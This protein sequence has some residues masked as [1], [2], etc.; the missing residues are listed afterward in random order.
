MAGREQ[1]NTC[2]NC[3]TPLTPLSHVLAP[4]P[5]QAMAEELLDSS[6]VPALTGIA[7]H[8]RQPRLV[9][10]ALDRLIVQVDS[11]S[12]LDFARL[13]RPGGVVAGACQLLLLLQERNQLQGG[14]T[15]ACKAIDGGGGPNAG[16]G[17]TA[18]PGGHRAGKCQQSNV[19]SSSMSPAPDTSSESLIAGQL[20]VA[21][22]ATDQTGGGPQKEPG[23][24]TGKELAG[25]C[26][27]H[28]AGPE[29]APERQDP[30]L[31]QLRAALLLS[32]LDRCRRRGGL[33]KDQVRSAEAISTWLSCPSVRV[34][35]PVMNSTWAPA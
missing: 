9:A 2:T 23:S 30:H 12:G 16:N 4:A 21:G 35:R 27:G 22:T 14:C 8:A 11:C 1:R 31:L 26:S 33:T 17:S 6:S 20:V 3:L 7:M 5:K 10:A 25:S 15:V 34:H 24:C 29:L 13:L 19:S 18:A 28:G 32:C